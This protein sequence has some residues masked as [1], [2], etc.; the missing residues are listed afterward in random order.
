M[1]DTFADVDNSSADI[2]NR[3]EQARRRPPWRSPRAKEGAKAIMIQ[4][5]DPTRMLLT[6][7]APVSLSLKTALNI[8][9]AYKSVGDWALQFQHFMKIKAFWGMPSFEGN[10]IFLNRPIRYSS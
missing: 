9:S 8:Q 2:A 7:D 5:F 4:L 3:R 6:R 10:R 1:L